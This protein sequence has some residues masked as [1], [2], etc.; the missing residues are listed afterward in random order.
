MLPPFLGRCVVVPE[1]LNQVTRT[2]TP[3]ENALVQV[4]REEEQHQVWA[5]VTAV[6]YRKQIQRQSRIIAHADRYLD[7]SPTFHLVDMS[8]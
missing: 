2:P 8:S 5:S 7:G 6:Y 1:D 3:P 4:Y